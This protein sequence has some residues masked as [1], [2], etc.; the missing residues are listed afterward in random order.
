MYTL[1]RSRVL[2]INDEM[3]LAPIIDMV[4]HSF[5]PNCEVTGK[6]VANNSFVILKSAKAIEPEEELSIS[7]GEISNNELFFKYNFVVSPNP[8]SY[9]VVRLNYEEAEDYADILFEEKKGLLDK[10]GGIPETIRVLRTHIDIKSMSALRLY[11]MDE[12]DLKSIGRLNEKVLESKI[13]NGNEIRV[14]Q[15]LISNLHTAYRFMHHG[16]YSN[17]SI[18]TIQM[19]EIIIIKDLLDHLESQLKELQ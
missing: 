10:L 16:E 2:S 7:Y 18:E 5:E 15:F 17:K 9:M 12:S 3:V 6:Y 1:T 14:I 13:S 11:F 4:N 19:E 8:Y